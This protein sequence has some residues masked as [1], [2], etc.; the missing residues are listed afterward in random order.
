MLDT[1]ETMVCNLTNLP[2]SKANNEFGENIPKAQRPKPRFRKGQCIIH[3]SNLDRVIT[4][5]SPPY[6]DYEFQGWLVAPGLIGVHEC[7]FVLADEVTLWEPHNDGLWSW[8]TRVGG[9]EKG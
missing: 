2:R 7:N 3:A 5:Q 1:R 4:L 8:W 9:G 6:W